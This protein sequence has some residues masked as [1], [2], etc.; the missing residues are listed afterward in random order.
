M[1]G[2]VIAGNDAVALSIG[3][4]GGSVFAGNDATVA[5]FGN[6]LSSASVTAN[7]DITDIWAAGDINGSFTATRNIGDILSYGS[8]NASFTAN[9]TSGD[10]STGQIGSTTAVGSIA[11]SFSAGTSIGNLLAGGAITATR[12][13]PTLGTVTANDSATASL[14]PPVGPTSSTASVLAALAVAQGMMTQSV[15]DYFTDATQLLSDANTALGNAQFNATTA[16]GDAYFNLT[17]ANAQLRTDATDDYNQTETATNA[18]YTNA[19]NQAFS[20]WNETTAA[21]IDMANAASAANGGA[22]AD[23]VQVLSDVDDQFNEIATVMQQADINIGNLDSTASAQNTA[24][25]A[26]HPI[27]WQQGF[28][29]QTAASGSSV[30][31]SSIA[32]NLVYGAAVGV[33]VTIVVVVAAPF[34]APIFAAIG[35]SGAVATYTMWGLGIAG[36]AAVGYSTYVSASNG[37]W[38]AVAFNAGG[39]AGGFAAGPISRALPKLRATQQ[40]QLVPPAAPTPVP[41]GQ[42]HHTISTK[43]GREVGNHP[44]LRG[45]Y[46]PRDPRF[47]TQAID[48]AA[49]R[50]YQTWHRR[51][52]DEV[53]RWL[54]ENQSATTQEFESWLRWRYR[55]PDLLM[56][57]PNGF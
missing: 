2:A 42:I 15:N 27:D 6:F 47:T 39:I 49:H 54:Q 20:A 44:T 53:V 26:Q 29:Q 35:I 17:N 13:A 18:A 12:T 5:S 19:R 31:L 14:T 45:Q 46:Q 28:D 23:S 4:F 22:I 3:H 7:R 41:N 56:R 10:S 24:Q 21:A 55:Q 52:D 34:V 30:T 25:I 33:G 9:G 40:P 11:G 37:D 32:C 50:G 51:L 36:T 1:N 38:N 48:D 43:I 16:L 8:I 57:F